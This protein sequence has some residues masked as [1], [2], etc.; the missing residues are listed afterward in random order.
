MA[1]YSFLDVLSS[2]VGP[3]GAIPLASSAGVTSEGISIEPSEDLNTMAIGADGRAMHSLHASHGGHVQIRL[4]KTSPINALLSVMLA[5][6]RSSG[7]LHGQNAIN[8]TNI[9][10][11]DNIICQQ[12]AFARVPSVNY[13]TEADMIEWRFDVGIMNYVLGANV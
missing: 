5:L 4:Q 6:Q 11:G 2:I 10:T 8:V 9:A 13:K 3:G 7:A 12:C 1:T